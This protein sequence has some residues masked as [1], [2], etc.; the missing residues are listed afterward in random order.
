MKRLMLICLLILCLAPAGVRSEEAPLPDPEFVFGQAAADLP[1]TEVQQ[2]GFLTRYE[3]LNHTQIYVFLVRM[4]PEDPG[5]PPRL[6]GWAVAWAPE[7]GV[8]P[9]GFRAMPETAE[10]GDWALPEAEE[11]REL[12]RQIAEI[13]A[14]AAGAS[15]RQAEAA[16]YLWLT[17]GRFAF[18]R[19]GADSLAPV[20]REAWRGLTGEQRARFSENAPGVLAEARRLLDPAEETGGIYEDADLARIMEALRAENGIRASA[21]ALIESCGAYI[22]EGKPAAD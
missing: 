13:P 21:A 19:F 6:G 3:F 20:F 1:G 10:A 17:G 11:I 22:G 7:S 18:D 9:M 8:V 2:I 15:L 14:G 16:V 5:Q 4:I 12:F